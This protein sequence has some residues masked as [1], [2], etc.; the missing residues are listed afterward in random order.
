MDPVAQRFRT[1][2]LSGSPLPS[3]EAAVRLLGAVQAQ[4]YSGAKWSLGQR[5]SA[6]TDAAIDRELD[7]GRILRTH[8]LRPTWHFVARDDIRWMLEQSAPRVLAQSAY[9][10]RRLDLDAGVFRRTHEIFE[11][12]LAGARHRTRAELAAALRRR[13]IEA[14]GQRLA[15]IV[16]EAELTGVVC[17][18]ALR[19]KQHTYALLEE[20][21]PGARRLAPDEALAELTRRFFEG[22]G[23]ATLR[24]CAW[25]GGLTL[26]E[27]RRGIEMAGTAL[28]QVDVGRVAHWMRGD[29]PAPPAR[30]RAAYLIPEY[31]EALLGYKEAA[32]PDLPRAPGMERRRAAWVRPIVIRGGR[33]GTWRRTTDRSEVLL[34]T[35]VLARLDSAEEREVDKAAQRLGRFLGKPVRLMRARR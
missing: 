21:A 7:Q 17:S 12:E 13:R 14:S 28:R 31:D 27:A 26:G 16:A 10:F 30:D 6:A 5:M 11:R 24:H 33:A 3:A 18:G 20:R 15:Y 32:L 8:V 19:G 9:Y 1:Q 4:D 35:D 34:E 25:W 29:S 23:P 22:H 2:R